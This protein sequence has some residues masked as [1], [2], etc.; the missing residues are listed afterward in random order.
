M[1]VVVPAH[2]RTFHKYVSPA[3]SFLRFILPAVGDPAMIL[4]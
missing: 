4:T 1:I 3:Q 2:R